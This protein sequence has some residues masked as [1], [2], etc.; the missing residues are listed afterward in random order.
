M[1]HS[2]PP[3]PVRPV[4]A[5]DLPALQAWLPAGAGR[6]LP[7]TDDEAWLLVP[8]GPE[9]A[10]A[11]CLRL[12]SA[13]GLQRP[14]HWYHVGCVVHAAPELGLF[15]R[16]GTL[17]LGN[18][19]TGAS[20]LAD[21]AWNPALDLPTQARALRQLLAHALGQIAANRQRY[22][23]HLIVELPGLRDEQGLSPFW[24]ALGRHF[25]SGNP[26]QAQQRL[27]PAWVGH[28]AALMPRQPVYTAFLS[29]A[30]QAAIAQT[31]PAWRV[32]V[33]LLWHAGLRYGHHITLHDGGPVFEA[34]MAALVMPGIEGKMGPTAL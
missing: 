23:S 28:V 33:D 17:Q 6:T 20:E 5:A 29:D 19:H 2:L 25:Y 27:G 16:L 31:P 11:A 22:A 7:E 15:H 8:A 18:D 32:L 26:D 13:I 1:S 9:G 34:P 14:R 10:P 4:L 21:I 24:Q 30:A 3:W 12:R